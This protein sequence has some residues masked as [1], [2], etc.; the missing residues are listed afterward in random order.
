M[1]D[2]ER[3]YSVEPVEHQTQTS[4]LESDRIH[5]QSTF[6][7]Q[8]GVEETVPAQVT[9]PEACSKQR[10]IEPSE[11][12][13]CPVGS[14]LDILEEIRPDKAEQPVLPPYMSKRRRVHKCAINFD[15][16]QD[17]LP[18]E[19]LSITARRHREEYMAQR[20]ISHPEDRTSIH[21]TKP[22]SRSTL[23]KDRCTSA[24]TPKQPE[25]T[26]EHNEHP[27]D[28]FEEAGNNFTAIHSYEAGQDDN[29]VIRRSFHQDVISSESGVSLH[30]LVETTLLS[31]NSEPNMR[32]RLDLLT[33]PQP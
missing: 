5:G 27:P 2:S 8:S 13:P 21:E 11:T 3:A 28:T 32:H 14:M 1:D 12:A 17:E 30:G 10:P 19:D 31:A 26:V 23:V 24:I 9:Q 33:S 25:V 7:L 29:N 20:K 6:A 16:S 18:K 4:S 22:H 15:F